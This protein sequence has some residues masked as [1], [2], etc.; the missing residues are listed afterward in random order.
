[1]LLPATA[2]RAQSSSSPA[3]GN[4]ASASQPATSA[5]TSPASAPASRPGGEAF[6]LDLP[7]PL[8]RM[9]ALGLIVLAGWL[10]IRIARPQK[11]SLAA[12]PFRPASLNPLHVLVLLSVYFAPFALLRSL[13]QGEE[14]SPEWSMAMLLA[15]QSLLII[16]GLVVAKATFKFGMRNGL[17]LNLRHPIMD[18]VRG[19]LGFLASL[20][21]VV[22]LQLGMVMLLGWFI[23]QGWLRPDVI[24][25][26]EM[27]TRMDL[28]S[29]GEKAAII[30]SVVIMAPLAEEIFFR[31]ITQSM[32]RQYMRPWPAII[33]ASVFFGMM[34]V[35]SWQDVVAL[36][37]LGVILGYN[38]ERT[39][40]LI[41]PIVLHAT[42]NGVMILLHLT[43]AT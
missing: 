5:A 36:I 27:F 13:H 41:S 8:M 23:S 22:G 17:G 25:Q 9:L 32:L 35:P 37:A 10:C 19:L 29:H 12:S 33:L 43:K 3:A 7:G 16:G 2:A 18:V 11:V 1:M 38:Y 30:V 14:V 34:H 39:G 15:S 6:T 31:G 4:T 42:F 20:P 28:A 26:N 24:M 40:R 21:V